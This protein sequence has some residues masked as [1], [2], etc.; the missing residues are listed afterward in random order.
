[1]AEQRRQELNKRSK[2]E[3]VSDIKDLELDFL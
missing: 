1:M 3:L 2:D